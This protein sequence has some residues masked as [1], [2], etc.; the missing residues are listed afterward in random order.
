MSAY[1]FGVSADLNYPLSHKH[2]KLTSNFFSDEQNRN[3]IW[4]Q[5]IGCTNYNAQLIIRNM[6]TQ[7]SQMLK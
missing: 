2:M 7:T 3:I 1:S 6:W 5:F 4:S